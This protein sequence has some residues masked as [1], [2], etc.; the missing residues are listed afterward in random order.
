[1]N[2]FKIEGHQPCLFQNQK[3]KEK[4]ILFY[5]AKHYING[6][7]MIHAVLGG[8]QILKGN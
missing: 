5:F 2:V 8:R 4:C 7:E 1:M 3:I 6:K